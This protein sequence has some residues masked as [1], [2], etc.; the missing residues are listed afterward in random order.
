MQSEA[1]TLFLA[2][3]LIPVLEDNDY[4]SPQGATQ[5]WIAERSAARAP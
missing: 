2:S 3:F 1:E 5:I 4:A